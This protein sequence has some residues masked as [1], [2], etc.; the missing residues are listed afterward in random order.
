[1]KA[2]D[3]EFINLSIVGHGSGAAHQ[4]LRYREHPDELHRLQ[5]VLD[6][7]GRTL[8]CAGCVRVGAHRETAVSESRKKWWMQALIPGEPS[9][10]S[11]GGTLGESVDLANL[12]GERQQGARRH[13]ENKS[14]Q[15][16]QARTVQA[17]TKKHL[18]NKLLCEI[19]EVHLRN[20]SVA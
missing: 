16:L 6:K 14:R 17:S 13:R 12:K 1:M 7:Y 19:P 8:G 2:R 20:E 9:D 5:C 4:K 15:H 3:H 11:S 18:V 10:P